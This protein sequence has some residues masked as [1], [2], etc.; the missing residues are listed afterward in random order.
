MFPI[1]R[2]RGAREDDAPC[3]ADAFGGRVD[4]ICILLLAIT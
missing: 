3:G 2:G 1:A 4:P